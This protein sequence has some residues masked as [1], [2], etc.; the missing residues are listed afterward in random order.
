ME[1]KLKH[2]EFLQSVITRMNVNSFFVKGWAVTLIAA[3]FAFAAKD[4]NTK[5]VFITIVTTIIFW[6]LDAYYLSQDRQYRALFN[7]VRLKDEESIDFN[8]N[9]SE[10]N[11]GKNAWLCCCSSFTI[12]LFYITLL[13][14]TLTVTMI[15]I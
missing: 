4:S 3:M 2:L 6:L 12:C 7:E 8:M 1:R 11:F 9:A 13:S 10:F 14:L 5:Y 15:I